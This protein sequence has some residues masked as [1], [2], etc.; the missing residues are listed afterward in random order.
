MTHEGRWRLI[1]GG[2]AYG[3][4]ERRRL[5]DFEANL[6]SLALQAAGQPGNIKL[7]SCINMSLHI[8]CCVVTYNVCE[9]SDFIFTLAHKPV[10]SADPNRFWRVNGS[11]E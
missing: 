9:Q 6:F 10:P 11:V 8:V 3:L 7:L 2:C 4:H 5:L 1:Q